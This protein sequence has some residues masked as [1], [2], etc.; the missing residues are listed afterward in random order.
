MFSEGSRDMWDLLSM[1]KKPKMIAFVVLTAVLYVALLY[2]FQGLT[3]FGGYA[4]FGRVG[5]GVPVAFSF[6]FGPAAG[7]GA[8]I[9]NVVRDIVEAHL[10]ASSFFGFVGNLIIGYVPFKLWSALTSE[11]PDLRSLKKFGLFV[12][13]SVL[14]CVLCG[15]TIGWGL[16]WLGFTPFM[17]TAAIIAITNSLWAIVA[18]SIL[19]ATT[20]N[21]VSKRK[22]L[23]QDILG[24]TENVKQGNQKGVAILALVAS[25]VCCFAVGLTFDFTPLMLLPFVAATL[26]FAAVSCR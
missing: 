11:K 16:Y 15:L 24:K 2:P 19:L 21:Y 18:G 26:I 20:Y 5:V 25:S 12:G 14:A 8:A 1:W 22:L 3:A 7:W 4:D 23:H 17:P 10:D 13:V 9:G 6:L